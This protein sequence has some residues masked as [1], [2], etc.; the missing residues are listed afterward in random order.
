VSRAAVAL[1]H[2]YLTQQGGAERVAY[3]M[4]Q[5]FPSAPLYTTL[6]QPAT[7]FEGFAAVDVRAS[8]L[9]R[10]GVLRSHHR[11]AL[12]LLAPAAR[13]MV[14]DAAVVLASSSGWAH[15]V[16]TSGR[17]VVYC[18]AP[19]RWLYQSQR[20]LG[21]SKQVGRQR[22]RNLP[23]AAA[24][25]ILTGPLR[26]WDQRAALSADRY[27]VNSTATR[28]AVFETYGIEAEVLAPPPALL[29][30]G[31]EEPIQ[32]VEPGAL[33]CVA[34][35]LPYKNVDA[36]IAAVVSQPELRLVVAGDGPERGRLTQ[37]GSA[38][39]RVVVLGRVTEA[40]LRWLYRHCS[41]LVAASYEDY[42][43]SPLEAAAFGRPTLALRA[44]GYLDTVVE[45][46]TGAFFS[47][48][49]A[50]AV[51]AALESFRPSAYDPAN[52]IE[53]AACFSAARFADEL[54]RIVA[55]EAELA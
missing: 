53:H 27:I 20:Y 4:A 40:Q 15:G 12:P 25:G 5:A 41:A 7:T 45:E 10:I 49:T 42:G 13:S 50:E 14:I 54:H 6:Y 48:P 46:R 22:L 24:L 55:Q 51:S 29:P 28:R 33:L 3:L 31:P 36:V 11:L 17:K 19:A 43:L 34:R 26:A 35:L 39:K 9:N 38:S 21:T 2:D 8:A 52:L 1:V 44:G 37:L 23:A 47:Q 16:R 18:H 32:G 30:D